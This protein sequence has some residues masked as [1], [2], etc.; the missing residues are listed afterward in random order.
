[1][2]AQCNDIEV[3]RV[4]DGALH[5]RPHLTART[6]RVDRCSDDGQFLAAREY[7]VHVSPQHR[8]D[9][10]TRRHLTAVIRT[11]V[12]AGCFDRTPSYRCNAVRGT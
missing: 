8:T 1:M 4:D 10:R 2:A 9:R 6:C 7:P 3:L 12:T 5:P 11:A